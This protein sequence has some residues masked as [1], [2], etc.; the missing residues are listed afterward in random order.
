[1]IQGE[2]MKKILIIAILSLSAHPANS[3]KASYDAKTPLLTVEFAHKVRQC[4]GSLCIQ[5]NRG[6]K[7]QKDDRAKP[8]SAG[9]PRRRLPSIQNVKPQN[10]DKVKVT[11][12]CNKGGNK[13]TTS[14]I[15]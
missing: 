15:P 12:D 11:A 3:V 7:R 5:S 2:Q 4:H 14:T 1:M 8:F 10:S 9:K 13:A 6:I